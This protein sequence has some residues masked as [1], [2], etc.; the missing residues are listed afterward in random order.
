MCEDRS[1]L[2]LT[3][4]SVSLSWKP[5]TLPDHVLWIHMLSQEVCRDIKPVSFPK[6]HTIFAQIRTIGQWGHYSQNIC[7]ARCIDVHPL[8]MRQCLWI[9]SHR[10]GW[11]TQGITDLQMLAKEVSFSQNHHS[12]LLW[13]WMPVR[14]KVWVSSDSSKCIKRWCT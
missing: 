12:V 7:Q 3:V 4:L 1:S 2:F 14:I 11:P 8:P 13:G 5:S 10:E 9:L 6:S